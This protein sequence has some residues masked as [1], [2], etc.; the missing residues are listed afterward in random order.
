MKN[1]YTDIRN[2]PVQPKY[3]IKC[4]NCGETN[5]K[6]NCNCWNCNNCLNGRL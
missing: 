6:E 2:F 3:Y 4:A 5:Y 1:E